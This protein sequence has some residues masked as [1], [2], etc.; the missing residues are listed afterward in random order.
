MDLNT[1]LQRFLKMANQLIK[2]HS[3]SVDTKRK[4]KITI[5]QRL[6]PTRMGIIKI[7]FKRKITSAG[8]GMEKLNPLLVEYKMVLWK[9]AW[10]ILRELNIESPY[11]SAISLLG[12]DSR[13]MIIYIHTK[14]YTQIFIIAVSR[15]KPNGHQ[16]RNG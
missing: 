4:V 8:E 1:C 13:K 7:F 11:D 2:R 9:T 10:Q 6:T 12:T 3:P 5:R 15:K 14:T 16:L